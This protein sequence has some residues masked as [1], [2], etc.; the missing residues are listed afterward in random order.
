MEK[1]NSR[2]QINKFGPKNLRGKNNKKIRFIG[3]YDDYLKCQKGLSILYRKHLCRIARLFLEACFHSKSFDFRLIKSNDVK[4][5]VYQYASRISPKTAQGVASAIRCFLQFLKFT[6]QIKVDL[7]PAI[8]SIACWIGDKA[9]AYL[10]D[11]EVTNLLKHCNRKTFAGLR[12]YTIISLIINLGLRAS[13]VAKLTLDDIDWKN[14]EIIVKGKGSINSRLPL[15][16]ELGDDLVLYLRKGRPSSPLR[17]FFVSLHPPHTEL[18]SLSI[19]NIIGRA[20]ERADLKKKGKAHLLRH[21]FATR[22]L[23][24]GA[25]LQEVRMLLRHKCINT[26]V[27]YAKVDFKKLR[28]LAFP[29]PK[30]LIFG[31]QNENT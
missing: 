8:P 19:T 1:R 21:T 7:S 9:P 18:K 3:L 17:F 28:S 13:E 25:D 12:D 15:T 10:L 27:I 31:G 11:Q 14:G 29:W 4:H 24:G 16:Q 6:N 30:D 2:P 22:L 26:T 5:F 23:G 20:F